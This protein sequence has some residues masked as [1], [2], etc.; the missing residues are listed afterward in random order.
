M[1][2]RIT[3][4]SREC[5]DLR[6]R[7]IHHSGG[8]INL[9]KETQHI[10]EQRRRRDVRPHD[11]T[12]RTDVIFIML[13][14]VCVYYGQRRKI[15]GSRYRRGDLYAESMSSARPFQTV[16][17]GGARGSETQC[18]GATVLKKKC[19][20]FFRRMRN[21]CIGITGRKTRKANGFPPN[22]VMQVSWCCLFL[23]LSLPA[24]GAK[25]YV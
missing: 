23:P 12:M 10:K 19:L 11:T 15:I 8:W 14:C 1:L 2:I 9:L 16:F 17:P 5:P 13:S 18:P 22:P 25:Q 20:R 24:Y 7:P 6:T 21:T 4:E 3:R